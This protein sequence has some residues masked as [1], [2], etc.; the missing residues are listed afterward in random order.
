M[1]IATLLLEIVD[2]YFSLSFE[3]IVLPSVK[4]LLKDS[5]TCNVNALICSDKDILFNFLFILLK[6]WDQIFILC[7]C[8]D[9]ADSY[10]ELTSI[11]ELTLSLLEEQW[12]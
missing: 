12:N 5:H 2:F 9:L 3:P 8:T 11:I 10:S 6:S 7:S 1:K 4:R